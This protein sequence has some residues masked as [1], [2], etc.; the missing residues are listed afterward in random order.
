MK[1][2]TAASS[3][4]TDY[5]TVTPL[6]EHSSARPCITFTPCW[7]QSSNHT[8]TP[9]CFTQCLNTSADG[10]WH[11]NEFFMALLLL[12]AEHNPTY[13]ARNY[14][15]TSNISCICAANR[16]G[17]TTHSSLITVLHTTCY[18]ICYFCN[19][20][21]WRAHIDAAPL[22]KYICFYVTVL[23]KNLSACVWCQQLIFWLLTWHVF[24]KSLK[25]WSI[26]NY[27]ADFLMIGIFCVSSKFFFHD[28]TLWIMKIW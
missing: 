13:D 28:S 15:A 1:L 22:R 21:E 26:V 24:W 14:L 10:R 20:I 27:H 6:N 8:H 25:M 7:M 2:C 3:H 11:G 12:D 17:N 9:P 18:Y 5:T 16:T 19:A 23:E 4:F